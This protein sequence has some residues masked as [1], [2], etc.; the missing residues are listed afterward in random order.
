MADRRAVVKRGELALKE[1]ELS[2][3]TKAD[4]A[5]IDRVWR[6][7]RALDEEQASANAALSVARRLMGA[8]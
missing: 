8:D 6:A 1:L 5:R 4:K 7:F 2:V 3:T